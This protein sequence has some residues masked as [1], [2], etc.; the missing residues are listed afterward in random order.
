MA[1]VAEWSN[2]LLLREKIN[3]T[4]KIPGSPPPVG[5]I[6]NIKPLQS[7]VAAEWLQ[8]PSS[9]F[10]PYSK[11]AKTKWKQLGLRPKTSFSGCEGPRRFKIT[12]RRFKRRNKKLEAGILNCQKI[13]F[14]G[15]SLILTLKSKQRHPSGLDYKQMVV[16]RFCHWQAGRLT[17]AVIFLGK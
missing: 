7:V 14:E 11:P 4:H 3:K 15:R 8:T 17:T 6:I 16:L 13:W 5:A 1:A 9:Q 10:Q 2:A 12:I